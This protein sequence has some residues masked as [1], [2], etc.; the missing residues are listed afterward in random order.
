MNKTG[1]ERGTRRQLRIHVLPTKRFKTFAISL[2]VG[3][4]LREETV[5]RVGLVPFVLRRGTESYPQTTQFREQLEQL[6]GAGFGFDVY[7][8]GDYQIVQFRMD[9]IND[10]F[11]N[12][13]D[14]LLDRSFAFLGEVLTK[15]ALE[16]GAFQTGYVQQEREN[17]R[18]KLESIVN[19]KIRYAGERCM[20][21]M[22]KDEPYRL[23]PLGQRSDLD[24]ISAQSLYE[25]Y[26]EW[27]NNASM[28]LYVVGDTTLEEVEKFV[29]RYFQLN[30][31]T[32]TEYV[33]EQPKSVER[34][35]QTIVER[36]DVNQGKLNM[37]LRTPITYGDE[38]YASALMYNG[39]LGGYPH[40]KLFVNVREK[41]SLAYYASSRYDGHKGI[42]T[43]Q[44][45][46]EIPNYEK[47]VTIIRKQLE[48][49][50]NGAIT[51]LEM[52]QTQAMI[53]NLL[54][55]MQDS[56]FE[57][58]AYDFNRQL[59]GKERTVEE[60]LSQVEAVKVQDVQDAAR[61]FRLDTIYFLRDQKGE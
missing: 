5:T 44:S 11:V 47:A 3:T 21:E 54:K 2:Y 29:D 39:I 19:D 12:S 20:E 37:G 7:K 26:G 58:I 51:E 57:M 8:R 10:S 4:P 31:S 35:V 46:I 36:L 28:D 16:N 52:T 1:F 60:L 23:H 17:V 22:C 14:S 43:I 42:G 25:A 13:P 55:E 18:K 56:A 32:E 45:G 15:P 6:Y 49:T 40:S 50:Q 38:R 41:E 24:S 53:R 33:L 9:T 34:D 30:R 27:L 61:T 59:S 48:D